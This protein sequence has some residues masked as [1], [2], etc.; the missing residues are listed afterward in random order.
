MIEINN[1]TKTYNIGSDKITVLDNVSLKIEKGEFVA[2]VG[3]S[4]SGKSTLMNMIGGLDRPTSG[5]VFVEG[6]D[7]SKFKDKDMS[8]FRNE[9]IG[10]VFQ[11]FNLEPTLTALE[12]VMMPLMIAGKSDREMKDKASSM[13]EALGMGNRK[14]HK[15]TELS[16]GQKQRVSI[17]RA[18]VNNPKIILADE[19]TGNLDSKSGKAVMDILTNFKNKGYTVIMVTHNI[20]DAGFADRIIKIK[21]GKVEQ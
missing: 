9:K 5:D 18:L 14:K 6:E 17:A 10:F 1:I 13:L 19:P 2:I 3:P 16:G 20:E 8:K 4:G 12:N 7:I 15:P 11:S 21:D